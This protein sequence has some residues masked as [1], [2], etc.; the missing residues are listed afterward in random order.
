MLM[1]DQNLN[2]DEKQHL[3]WL[4]IGAFVASGV[5][6]VCDI[7]KNEITGWLQRRRDEKK[8]AVKP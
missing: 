1:P 5:A 3:K 7:S 4:V 2:P 8:N 6:A